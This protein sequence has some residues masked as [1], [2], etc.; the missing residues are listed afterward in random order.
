MTP[1]ARMAAVIELCRLID[2][3]AQPADATAERF[4]RQRRFMGSKD[5]RAVADATFAMLRRRARLDWWIARAGGGVEPTPRN[6]AIA[7]LILFEGTEALE[8]SSLFNGA[9]HCPPP[10]SVAETAFAAA[11]WGRSADHSD[12]P[13]ATALEL[14]AW[15]EEPL[16][17]QWGTAVA[18]EMGALNT[19][20]PV[21]LRVNTVKATR[22]KARE[23]LAADGIETAPT[24]LSPLGLRAVGRPRLG[25]AEA[26]R[27]GLVEVQDEGAQV[28]ALLTGARTGMTVV[29][30]CAG[31]GGKT[32]VVAGAMAEGS[33]VK[34]RLTAC[35][36]VAGRLER[37]RGRLRRAGISGVKRRRLD[38]ENT[39]WMAANRASAERV[40]VDAPCSGTGTW[41]RHPE[42]RWRLAAAAVADHVRRQRKILAAAAA[43]VRR[44]GRLL[45]VT[46]SLLPVENE[47]QVA[48]FLDGHPDFALIPAAEAWAEAVG[49]PCPVG[50]PTLTLS[51]ASTGTDGFFAA[52]LER[53]AGK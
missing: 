33:R 28:T 16:R 42:A 26:F 9:G 51:P 8:L 24:P 4:F 18:A 43:L 12:M 30:F 17:R 27:R 49:G 3:T 13:A 20:A 7:N 53:R 19:P 36:T 50:G 39:S 45:Y 21:D 40:L 46:C 11:L 37:L 41:R 52:V 38:G 29:D 22:E 14:P 48:G 44:G 25:A 15:L 34:G 23:A 35:D 2:G 6:R 32:L 47:E 31:A 5:R 1:G 10:L